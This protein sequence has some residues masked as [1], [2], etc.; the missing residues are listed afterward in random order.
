MCDSGKIPNLGNDCFPEKLLVIEKTFLPINVT[1]AERQ[2]LCL[3]FGPQDEGAYL[4]RI[5]L[6]TK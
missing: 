5:L 6:P 1:L 4:L 2:L 3:I